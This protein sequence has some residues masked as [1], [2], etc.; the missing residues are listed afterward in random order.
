MLPAATSTATDDARA[1][2][3]H[4]GSAAPRAH[5][6]AR[7]PA[8]PRR[9]SAC[10][11][12]LPE[13]R[14][15]RRTPHTR[16]TRDAGRRAHVRNASRQGSPEAEHETRGLCPASPGPGCAGSLAAPHHNHAQPGARPDPAERC[17]ARS[18]HAANRLSAGPPWLRHR[19][20]LVPLACGGA[21]GRGMGSTS[22]VASPRL[23]RHQRAGNPDG[24]A[25]RQ[26]DAPALSSSSRDRTGPSRTSGPTGR[27]RFHP[28]DDALI[29]V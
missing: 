3:A 22:G 21:E 25:S 11:Q 18:V 2:P 26:R 4:P 20:Y 14:D 23:V 7:C 28:R 1:W 15:V 6:A 17:R 9:D 12:L 19:P 29:R 10:A 13:R 16:G 8:G 24:D 27:I 5:G